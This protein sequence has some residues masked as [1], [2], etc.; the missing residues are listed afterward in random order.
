MIEI[1]KKAQVLDPSLL[2]TLS[3]SP[4]P[5][6]SSFPRLPHGRSV[7]CGLDE[8]EGERLFICES[9]EDMQA[10]YDHYRRE[11]AISIAWYELPTVPM[12]LAA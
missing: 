9:L 2:I 8:G 3:I 7:L 5:R 1:G 6:P 10:L 11:S 12:A 4:S